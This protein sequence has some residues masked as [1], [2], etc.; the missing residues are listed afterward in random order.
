MKKRHLA[1][2]RWPKRLFLY[3]VDEYGAFFATILFLISDVAWCFYAFPY[4]G[5]LEEWEVRVRHTGMY[6]ELFGLAT[7]ALGIIGVQKKI[8]HKGLLA[9]LVDKVKRFPLPWGRIH[10]LEVHD[11]IGVSSSLSASLAVSSNNQVTLEERVTRLESELEKQGKQ[12]NEA[13]VEC[14]TRYEVQTEALAVEKCEREKGDNDNKQL[15]DD[16]TAGDLHIEGMGIFWLLFGILLATASSEIAP[17]IKEL[18]DP[19]I[20]TAIGCGGLFMSC[21]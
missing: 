14:K 10:Y 1:L 15:I 3:F 8:N 5:L 21:W 19:I 9:A 6:L 4:M 20:Q 13:K 16:L 18:L 11:A 17:Y 7:A 12:L 2:S